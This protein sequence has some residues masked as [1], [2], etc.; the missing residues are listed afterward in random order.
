MYYKYNKIKREI[1]FILFSCFS[2]ITYAQNVTVE[3]DPSCQRFIGGV[4]ELDRTKFFSIHD[5][6]SD[7]DALAFRNDYN[8][9]GGRDFWGPYGVA[10]VQS[11]NDP[12][13]RVAGVYPPDMPGNDNVR[14]VKKDFVMTSHRHWA[15]FDGM[16][17]S[18]AADWAAEYFKDYVNDGEV[19]EYFEVMNEP[20]VHAPDYGSDVQDI[21]HQMSLLYNEVGLRFNNTPALANMKVI[22]YSAAWASVELWDFGQWEDNMKMFMDTA[23]D[24][25]YGFSTHLYDGINV[26]GQDSKR[27]GSNSEAILD[28][29]EN[30]SF[31][32]WGKIKPHAITEYGAIETG[33]GPNY[34]EI[35]SSQTMSSIN[36]LLFNL[37][38]RQD[39]VTNSIPFIV[40]KSTWHIT[41][42][43]NYQPYTPALWIPS[44]IGQ[45]NPTGWHY[46]P[47]IHFYELWKEV[48]GERIFINSDNPD[49]QIHAFVDNTKMYVALSNLDDNNQTID[50]QMLSNQGNIANTVIKKSL[51][52]YPQQLPDMDIETLTSV[53]NSITLIKD[54]TV[55]LEYNLNNNITYEN[56]LRSKKH[57]STDYL[58]A[59]TPNT[60]ISYNFNNVTTGDGYATIRMSIS[61]DH[62]LSKQP[63][64]RVNGNTIPAPNNWQGYDQA[65][66]DQFFGMIEIPFAANL[67]EA[68]N[69]IT[70]EISFKYI[71]H[72]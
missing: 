59:I 16:D 29:I 32:K 66:R 60:P 33:Y 15:F 41:P 52:V 38:D 8:V 19:H 35:A 3:I 12:D 7:A 11:N 47:R 69:T 39:R 46:S 61:R 28:I 14:T 63:I 71:R 27:S 30:Y 6:A 70:I 67:I 1:S 54:E 31:I 55:V 48:K 53:P 25:M 56:A 57:F 58:Q 21:K 5:G 43:N 13:L 24:F 65:D 42:E 44:N 40:G 10:Y 51:R 18:A 45:P 72:W 49:I 68:N 37:L 36:H 17:V 23:G 64:I 9:T 34:S 50:L 2:L 4:S 20:F 26:V 62:N 22:G